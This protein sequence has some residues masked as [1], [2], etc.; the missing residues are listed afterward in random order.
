[1]VHSHVLRAWLLLLSYTHVHARQIL[2]MNKNDLFEG[3]VAHSNIKDHFP[4]Y[5]GAPG[6]AAAGRGYFKRR[7]LSV[8]QDWFMKERQVYIHTTTA[9][10]TEMPPPVMAAVEKCVFSPSAYCTRLQ[11]ASQP[12]GLN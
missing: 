2:F 11:L 4:D 3:K 9:T 10:D 7:F 8:A 6:D 12:R 5:D 1:V